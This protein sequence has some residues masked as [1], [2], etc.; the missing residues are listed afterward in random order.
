MVDAAVPLREAI[1][2]STM[3][4]ASGENPRP[5]Y[6]FGMIIEKKPCCLMNV[7]TCSGRSSSSWVISQSS[8]SR[9]SSSV[10]PSRNACSSS[11]S[12][13]GGSAASVSQSGMPENSCPSH[14]T[15]PASSASRSV[16]E[17]DGSMSRNASRTGALMR[18]R[19][20]DSTFS[21]ASAANASHSRTISSVMP[22][23]S[24]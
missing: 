5:P 9:Q 13:G 24:V 18:S 16:S 4:L 3:E 12:A 21:S 8:S 15:L 17:S 14:H 6:A 7:H 19:R 1:F 22:A 23:T 11:V 2:A 20:S 10:G